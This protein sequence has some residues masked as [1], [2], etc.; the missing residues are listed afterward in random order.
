MNRADSST[1][2]IVY[3][4]TSKQ[5]ESSSFLLP[6]SNLDPNTYTPQPST[7]TSGPSH[8]KEP[9]Q[10]LCLSQCLN[11]STLPA[12]QPT[13]ELPHPPPQSQ[14]AV[15]PR[16]P[17]EMRSLRQPITPSST[18]R[19]GDGMAALRAS[20]M[21]DEMRDGLTDRAEASRTFG[22]IMDAVAR[23]MNTTKGGIDADCRIQAGCVDGSGTGVE[24]GEPEVEGESD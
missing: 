17:L 13:N 14:E 2:T 23:R 16:K 8:I 22:Y 15:Y 6:L 3:I 7:T 5:L 10:S 12:P 21:Q 4:E 9:T 18:P 1:S 19:Y 20:Y 24:R 11:N